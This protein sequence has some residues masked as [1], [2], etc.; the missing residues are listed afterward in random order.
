MSRSSE[1][2]PAPQPRIDL[3]SPDVYARFDPSDMRARIA[4]LPEQARRAWALGHDWPLPEALRTP[5][6]RVVILA[7]GGSAVGG[8]VVAA[9]AASSSSVPVQLVRNYHLPPL[10]K[11]TLVVA[12][13]FSGETEESISAFRAALAVPGPR[14]AITTGGELAALARAAN[15]PVFAYQFDGPPR[16][17][18]GY[19]IFAL[20]AI[21]SRAGVL[22][23]DPD[24]LAATFNG[25]A[26]DGDRY[27]VAVPAA[28]NDAKE[29]ATWL[30]GRLPLIV[31]ADFLEVAARRWAAQISENAKQWAF[32]GAL[33]E[34]NH[35]LIMGIGSPPFAREQ[36]RTLLLDA[37][38]VHPRNRLRVQLTAREFASVDVATRTLVIPGES[39]L[40]TIVRASYL[41]DW[42]SLYLAMLNKADP[43]T[44][45]PIARLKAALAHHPMD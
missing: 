30:R 28:E 40:E 6:R 38:P 35:N 26:S 11:H 23:V 12:C 42:V 29:L 36:V 20:L 25:L 13:S 39:G 31:G 16:S 1:S 44:V 43:W 21:L 7:V 27:G 37:A 33:P 4:G 17:A 24:A 32:A 10:D 22:P 2:G 18:L 8:D 45:E 15:A 14:L 9:L 19:G 5:P 3:D 41:G 34:V